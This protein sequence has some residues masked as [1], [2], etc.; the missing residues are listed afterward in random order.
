MPFNLSHLSSRE[1][2]M[3]K[4]NQNVGF[5]RLMLL[6]KRQVGEGI[7]K[8]KHLILGRC[9]EACLPIADLMSWK[10]CVMSV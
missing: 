2:K 9:C 8:L 5:V 4:T 3:A 6:C 1:V 7:E 10:F